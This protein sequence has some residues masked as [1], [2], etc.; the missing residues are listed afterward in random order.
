MNKANIVI[1]VNPSLKQVAQIYI[2]KKSFNS[3]E[4]NKRECL[5]N[6]MA[7]ARGGFRPRQFRLVTY[8]NLDKLQ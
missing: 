3:R 2:A 5:E 7:I 8:Q 6:F 1:C 4:N